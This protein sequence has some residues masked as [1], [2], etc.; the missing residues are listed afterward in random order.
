MTCIRDDFS[1]KILD[2]NINALS[3]ESLFVDVFEEQLNKQ[4]H[5]GNIYRPPKNNNYNQSIEF[6]SLK[7]FLQLWKE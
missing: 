4:I 6:F 2:M 7:S 5:I 1:Y 3:L